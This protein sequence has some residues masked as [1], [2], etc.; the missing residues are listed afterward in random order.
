MRVIV[1]SIVNI[2]STEILVRAGVRE[3]GKL[4]I[5]NHVLKKNTKFKNIK[6]LT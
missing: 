3:K 1:G 2:A 6:A 4:K 5:C